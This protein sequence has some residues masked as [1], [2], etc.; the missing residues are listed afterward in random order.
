M[1]KNVDVTTTTISADGKTITA[2]M[3]FEVPTGLPK[4]YYPKLKAHF[5]T[6]D[7]NNQ[8][9]IDEAK[10][11]ID[12]NEETNKGKI[13]I[14]AT[15]KNTGVADGNSFKFDIQIFCMYSD[16]DIPI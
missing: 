16:T 9:T 10:V 4:E 8:F 5:S 3:E 15:T 2:E 1:Q 7:Y 6:G 12:F 14:P 11:R 13:S